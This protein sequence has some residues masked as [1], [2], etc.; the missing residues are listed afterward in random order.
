MGGQEE[1]IKENAKQALLKM[2]GGNS[3][4]EVNESTHMSEISPAKEKI[5]EPLEEAKAP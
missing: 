5:Q 4:N 3:M 2:V 1:K